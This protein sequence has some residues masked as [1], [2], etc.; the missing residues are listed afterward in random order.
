MWR[1]PAAGGSCPTTSNGSYHNAYKAAV[2]CCSDYEKLGG[3]W[4]YKHTC[5][6]W[7][8]SKFENNKCEKSSTYKEAR[9][10]CEQIGGRLCTEAEIDAKCTGGTGCGYNITPIWTSS[11]VG[12][13]YD[14]FPGTF[15]SKLYPTIGTPDPDQGYD[16]YGIGDRRRSD[17]KDGYV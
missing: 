5:N 16:Y 9:C 13:R 10:L 15:S 4:K 8:T 14:Y 2:S 12:Q 3:G 17:G 7:S 6:I 1:G 11:T